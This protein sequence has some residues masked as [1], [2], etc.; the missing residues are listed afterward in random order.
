MNCRP[1]WNGR[2]GFVFYV[3]IKNLILQFRNVAALVLSAF[4]VTDNAPA[5]FAIS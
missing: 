2:N 5:L 3:E 1:V 4:Y